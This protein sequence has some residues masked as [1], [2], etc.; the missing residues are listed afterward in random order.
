MTSYRKD[1][2]ILDQQVNGAP[3]VYLD[4]A[5]TSQK[6]HVVID[7]LKDYY[8]RYNANVHRAVH[9]LSDQA[10]VAF[11]H[12]RDRVREF[13]NAG[14]RN[15]IIF[16]RGTTES[17]NLVANCY[18][19]LLKPGDEILISHMEHHSNIVPWQMLA[20]RTNAVLKACDVNSQGDIDLESFAELLTDKTKIVA[21]AHVSNALGT[22]NPL[23]QI[24]E[25]AH[26]AGAVVVVDG[27]QAV[28]HFDVDVSALDCDFYAFSG[29]KMYGPT[30]I[31]VLYGKEKLL[32]VLPPWQGGGEMIETVSINK[33]TYNTLP[34]KFEAGTPN[35][36]GAIGLG[37]AIDYLTQ[38][39]RDE[40]KT[41]EDEL[42]RLTLSQLKQI[43]GVRLVGEPEKRISVVSFLVDGSH[44]HDVG[45]LLDQQGIAVRTGHHCAMPLMAQLGIPGTVRASFSLY[46]SPEDVD[47]LIAGVRKAVSFI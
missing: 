33:S 1:F 42:L 15:E 2:P 35:I 45:T 14:S 29:H 46:N 27:A 25:Q 8:H 10:T 39:P 41:S 44:P 18:T 13:V 4:N 34:Y 47:R 7:A 24:I 21:I 31:G 6:P 17:I 22:V 43:D 36:A 38:L 5:A 37:A 9:A 26:E 32:D 19:G 16:T 20:A 23:Q 28:P 40:I 11:E 3:L 12:A 30:G